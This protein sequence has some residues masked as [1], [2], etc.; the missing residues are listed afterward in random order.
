MTMTVIPLMPDWYMNKKWRTALCFDCSINLFALLR[1]FFAF[2]TT[3]R[4]NTQYNLLLLMNII[5]S[6][7]F[8]LRNTVSLSRGRLLNMCTLIIFLLFSS[9]SA[10]QDWVTRYCKDW[11]YLWSNRLTEFYMHLLTF[12]MNACIIS[13]L[14]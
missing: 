5:S 10:G 12:F 7:R 11:T 6:L 3:R 1:C 8:I 2:T 14:C 4:K 13:C 9:V